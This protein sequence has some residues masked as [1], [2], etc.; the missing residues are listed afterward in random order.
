MEVDPPIHATAS[1]LISICGARVGRAKRTS[2]AVGEVVARASARRGLDC[3]IFARIGVSV[4]NAASRVGVCRGEG[5]IK[6][7]SVS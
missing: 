6:F 5:E 7:K 3:A 2:D 4:R 1:A